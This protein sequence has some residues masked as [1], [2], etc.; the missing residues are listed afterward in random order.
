MYA[1]TAQQVQVRE[2]LVEGGGQLGH[3][4][5]RGSICC[6]SEN[7]IKRREVKGGEQNR[8]DESRGET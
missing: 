2:L 7:T 4:A 1:Y 5:L 3:S 8:G 6:I